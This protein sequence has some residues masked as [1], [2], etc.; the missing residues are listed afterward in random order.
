MVATGE[1]DSRL[2]YRLSSLVIQ[3]PALREHREDVPD[4]ANFMLTQLVES[5]I[6]PLRRLTTPALNPC[7]IS[8]GPAI[9]RSS[10]MWCAPWR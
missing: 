9:C 8:T 7:A 4:I 1:F 6:C 10:T 3:V 5:S 2:F